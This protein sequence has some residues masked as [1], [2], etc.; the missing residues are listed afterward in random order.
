MN[1]MSSGLRGWTGNARIALDT[2][3]LPAWQGFRSM[4][5]AMVHRESSSVF[6]LE[7]TPTGQQP[8]SAA[9]P[10][11][12][13]TLR[14]SVETGRPPLLRSYSLSGPSGGPRYRISI[15]QELHD[16]GGRHYTRGCRPA[17][18]IPSSAS[19]PVR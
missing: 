5:V 11:Q 8:L 9:A 19:R 10:G 15:K 17:G 3:P 1:G 16:A 7:F 18:S 2:G 4:G 6:S 14:L 13:V 12:F